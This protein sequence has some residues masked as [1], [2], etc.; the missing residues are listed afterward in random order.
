MVLAGQFFNKIKVKKKMK[1][2]KKHVFLY[3]QHVISKDIFL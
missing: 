1:D 3:F 2:L